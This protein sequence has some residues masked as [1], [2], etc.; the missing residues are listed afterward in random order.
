MTIATPVHPFATQP[1]SPPNITVD[2]ATGDIYYATHDSTVYYVEKY[3]LGAAASVVVAYSGSVRYSMEMRFNT[4]DNMLYAM[5]DDIM[6]FEFIKIDPS[7][8]SITS[9]TT[10]PWVNPDYYSATL[11]QC[12]NRYFISAMLTGTGSMNRSLLNQLSMSGV[13]VQTDTTATFYQGL[14]F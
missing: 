14:T 1:F 5:T 3:H 10:L 12:S 2:N 4:N 11:D 9:V 7:S 8:G 6:S 13:V